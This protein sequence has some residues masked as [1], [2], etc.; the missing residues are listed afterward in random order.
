VIINCLK[1]EVDCHLR[2]EH[3]GFHNG[4]SCNEQI[5]F[6]LY[7]LEQCKDFIDFKK[8]LT[9]FNL[10]SEKLYGVS[11]KIVK[12]IQMIRTANAES[13]PQMAILTRSTYVQASYKDA[14][15][16]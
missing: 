4:N 1:S 15:S 11:D 13:D 6:L 14:Y 10:E 12:Y 7:I 9:A 3:A 16:P 5:C 8:L 2:E